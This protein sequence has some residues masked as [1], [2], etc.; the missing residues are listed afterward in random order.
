LRHSGTNLAKFRVPRGLAGQTKWDG[1]NSMKE[2]KSCIKY[3]KKMENKVLDNGTKVKQINF[4]AN[5]KVY[6]FHRYMHLPKGK[7]F[8]EIWVLED[9]VGKFIKASTTDL[10][11]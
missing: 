6:A 3:A 2:Q 10:G 5:D 1:E 7:E 11:G 8:V 4:L 9:N